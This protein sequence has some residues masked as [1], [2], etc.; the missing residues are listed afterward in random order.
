MLSRQKIWYFLF[1]ILILVIVYKLHYIFGQVMYLLLAKK[2][3][4]SLDTSGPGFD[5]KFQKADLRN[6]QR[7][8]HLKKVCQE[9]K[10]SN[11]NFMLENF[12]NLP[13]DKQDT[14]GNIRFQTYYYGKNYIFCTPPKSGT[15]NWQ[16]ALIKLET[17]STENIIDGPKMYKMLP[18]LKNIPNPVLRNH[19]VMLDGIHE[20]DNGLSARELAQAKLVYQDFVDHKKFRILTTRH[21]VERLYSAWH[22]KFNFSASDSYRYIKLYGNQ[23]KQKYPENKPADMFCSFQDFIEY[24]LD[25]V[26]KYENLADIYRPEDPLNSAAQ[27][28]F[29]NQQ[30]NKIMNSLDFHWT[31]ASFQC[32]PCNVEYTHIAST[33]TLHEDSQFI[34]HN[35]FGDTN[36][37]TSLLEI[38]DKAK[39]NIQTILNSKTA[40]LSEINKNRLRRVLYWDLKLFNYTY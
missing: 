28:T 14:I 24:F 33:D 22:N 3:M 32:L 4:L 9:M 10:N 12:E 38:P 31:L 26:E 23:I 27:K 21:P 13:L 18:R 11:H 19:S 1:I 29:L 36:Y 30:F 25:K 7:L 39:S 2:T 8:D 40:L 6:Q 34:L 37:N 15:S 20:I 5:S 17:N 16:K 35:I